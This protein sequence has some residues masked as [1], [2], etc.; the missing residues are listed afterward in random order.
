MKVIIGID[1]G[2]TESGVVVWQNLVLKADNMENNSVIE[3]LR[4]M[5]QSQAADYYLA[6]E[7]VRGYGIMASDGLFDTCEWTGRFLQAFGPERTSLI[8]RKEVSKHIC[9]TGGISHDKFIREALIGRLGA[10]GT[11]KQPGPLYGISGHLW[12]ALAVALTWWDEN[13]PTLFV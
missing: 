6:V 12:A 8:P 7:R 3:W 5:R 11:K 1:P 13:T 4:V 2:P 9:G 10:V